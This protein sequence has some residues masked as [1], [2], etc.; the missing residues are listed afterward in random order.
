M[1]IAIFCGSSTGNNPEYVNEAEKLG[2]F[3]GSNGIDLVYWWWKSRIMGAIADAT[4]ANGGKVF[5]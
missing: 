5:A 3:F 2:A 4:L 1:K